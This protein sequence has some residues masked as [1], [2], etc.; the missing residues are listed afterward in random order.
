MWVIEHL[1]QT[2]PA[3]IWRLYYASNQLKMSGRKKSPH[4]NPFSA[5]PVRGGNAAHHFSVD[6]P[7]QQVYSCRET[8]PTN[9]SHSRE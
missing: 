6:G 4:L 1:S 8:R 5:K 3:A 2:I 7:L 9:C